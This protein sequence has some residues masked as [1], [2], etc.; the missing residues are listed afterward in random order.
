M[1]YKF[2]RVLKILEWGRGMTN[3]IIVY[4]GFMF[5]VLLAVLSYANLQG[6]S[7]DEAGQIDLTAAVTMWDGNIGYLFIGVVVVFLV[8]NVMPYILRFR[9]W[10]V[11]TE[12]HKITREVYLYIRGAN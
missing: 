11:H 6:I 2:K 9:N 3:Q 10:W 7:I 12:S 8:S 4:T 1:I 5:I